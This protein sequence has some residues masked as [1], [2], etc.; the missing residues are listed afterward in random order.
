M[1]EKPDTM[2]GRLLE[3]AHATG[4]HLERAVK[5]LDWLLE[6]DRWSDC[7]EG[8]ERIDDFL[9][10][11]T[12]ARFKI[13][14]EQRKKLAKKL[15]ELRATQRVIGGVLGVSKSTVS[16]DL[17][18]VQNRTKPET[19][20]LQDK[21]LETADVQNRTTPT[22][23]TG[24]GAEVV[25][26]AGKKDE[27]KAKAKEK[28]EQEKQDFEPFIYNIW[29]TVSGDDKDYFGHFLLIFMRNLLHYHTEE[30]DM[31]YDPFAGSGTTI[32]AAE[33]MNRNW[34][35][36]DINPYT[37]Q[38]KEWD[39]HRG[40]PLDLPDVDLAFLDPPYWRQAKNQYAG[41]MANM[42]LGQFNA[43]MEKLL[44]EL[45]ERQIPRIAI[46]IQPTQYLND[47]I[48]TDH[49]FDFHHMLPEYKIEMRYILPY[50]TQQYNAQ[51]VMRA[52]EE[53][54]T[55]CLNRDLVVWR[56]K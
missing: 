20:P 45:S 3:A 27:R 35:C 24:D 9:A 30:Q 43:A 53:R 41:D 46:V 34:Y 7:G 16:D 17:K 38:I 42:T 51:Q 36:S 11:I 1:I 22:V 49:V 32:E 12:L 2:H 25:K 13:E 19:K 44:T 47:F 56:K 5:E 54:K 6:D 37:E 26:E 18:P 21:E 10:T 31:V 28:R 52:K 29:N 33:L 50:S 40:L 48:W 39:I 55:L 14:V 8:Y 15:S 4:Y 23:I